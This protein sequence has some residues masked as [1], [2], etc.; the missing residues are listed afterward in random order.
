MTICRDARKILLG[1]VMATELNRAT[2]YFREN[3]TAVSMTNLGRSHANM[4][5]II[6]VL[7]FTI[8]LVFFF[9]STPE[10]KIEPSMTCLGEKLP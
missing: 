10:V 2:K 3:C 7:A 4:I 9:F 5:Q 8:S 6:L 1:V